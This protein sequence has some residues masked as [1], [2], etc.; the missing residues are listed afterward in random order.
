MLLI[1]NEFLSKEELHY[2]QQQAKQA[3]WEDGTKSAFG[4]AKN[5]KN[6]SQASLDSNNGLQL[7]NFLLSKMGNHPQF[8][9]AVLPHR[10]F[11][12]RVNR[13][14]KDQQY[15][16]HVDAAIMSIPGTQEVLR[17][18]VSITV[19]LNEPQEYDGGE[20]TIEGAF[21]TQQVKLKAGDAVVYPS[22]SLHSVS[23]VTRGYRLAAISW[24]QSMIPD[25]NI[26]EQLYHLDQSIQNLHQSDN[27][28]SELNRL[29][30]VYHNLIR[31]FA[32]L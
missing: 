31:H 16:F 26:R 24:I 22:A 13:Y 17:S 32:Q 20:L 11:P 14:E 8:V 30:N 25:S 12:P 21:G 18:D 10:I 15:G 3:L 6:N 1:I 9:S 23:T 28:K 29:S 5:V 2:M 4:V 7:S 19:F 27:H